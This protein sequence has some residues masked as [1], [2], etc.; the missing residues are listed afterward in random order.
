MPETDR[1]WE[2][3]CERVPLKPQHLKEYRQRIQKYK[4][5]QLNDSGRAFNFGGMW[6]ELETFLRHR[7]EGRQADGSF[8]ESSVMAA[9]CADVCKKLIKEGRRPLVF[10]DTS[11]EADH[12]L[13]VLRANGLYARSW[14]EV[15]SESRTKQGVII[16]VKRIHG[17]GINMQG[18]ADCVVCRPT[19]GDYLEQM[20]GRID[21]PGQST[22][23]LKLV[24]LVAEHTIEE[25]KFANIHLA[26]NFFREY[27]APVATAYR[28]RVDLEA[29]LAVGG[30]GKLETGMVEKEWRRS[31]EAAGQSG[32][33]F[34]FV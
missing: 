2:M 11:D 12:F 32:M 18:H 28:E 25:A 9:A 31:L 24:V 1:S 23:E 5:Q 33:F 26:G 10:A 34:V 20:K 13:G 16:A 19:P 22:K 29:T 27:I 4:R 8:S 17:Q 6:K 21:R 30:T 3:R 7:Y 15:S 14:S